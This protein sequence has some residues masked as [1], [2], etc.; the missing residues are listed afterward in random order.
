MKP[1]EEKW[2]LDEVKSQFI[3][4]GDEY[5]YALFKSDAPPGVDHAQL[6]EENAARARLAAQAPAMARVLLDFLDG[7]TQSLTATNA[8]Q[9]LRDA[10]V[11][12]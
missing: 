9:I 10:G 2:T 5:S 11:L 3:R 12:P 6:N 8:R 4:F 1:H 7:E